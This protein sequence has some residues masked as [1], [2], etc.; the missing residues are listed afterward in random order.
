MKRFKHNFYNFFF[1]SQF[2]IFV[3]ASEQGSEA[4]KNYFQ[5]FKKESLTDSCK[6]HKMYK[7]KLDLFY[8]LITNTKSELENLISRG[9]LTLTL[10]SGQFDKQFW[11]ASP[12]LKQAA[13]IKNKGRNERKG[14][15]IVTVFFSSK[16]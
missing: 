2:F 14:K 1:V 4:V 7:E 6:T 10:P 15:Q 5:Q 9:K 16:K 8:N 3:Y 13:M 12:G 11:I